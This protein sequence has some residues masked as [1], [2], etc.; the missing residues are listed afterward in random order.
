MGVI[1]ITPDSFSDGGRFLQVDQAVSQAAIQLRQGADVLDLC[2]SWVS[3]LPDRPLG[4]VSGLGM[5]ARELEANQRLTEF[6]QADLNA[7]PKL[8]FAAASFDACLN[9]VSVWIWP[10]SSDLS[11]W[12]F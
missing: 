6:V 10:W 12:F 7:E 9:V 11:S 1:N 3:H 8:P 2:S 4:R 5:N